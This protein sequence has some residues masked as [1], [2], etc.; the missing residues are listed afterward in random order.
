MCAVRVYFSVHVYLPA[1]AAAAAAA[2]AIVRIDASVKDMEA[3]SVA[4]AAELS[5]T[6]LVCIKVADW[7]T[8]GLMLFTLLSLSHYY[9]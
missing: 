4:W 6:P 9:Q 5:G 7:L 1:A 2:A 3:A 8:V